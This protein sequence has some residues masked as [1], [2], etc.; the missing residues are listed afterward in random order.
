MKFV[1]DTQARIECFRRSLDVSEIL[2]QIEPGVEEGVID[3]Y[4][5][6]PNENSEQE[7]SV[8]VTSFVDKGK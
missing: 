3:I 2:S 1:I 8:T 6:V 7:L 5:P 4:C